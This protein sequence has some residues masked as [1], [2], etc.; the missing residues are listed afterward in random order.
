M[1]SLLYTSFFIFTV[2]L[3]PSPAYAL[4]TILLFIIF[5]FHEKL[6]LN[7]KCLIF[8][9]ISI[10][11]IFLT[12]LESLKHP[13]FILTISSLIYLPIIKTD[14]ILNVIKE[15]LPNSYKWRIQM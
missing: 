15:N 7:Y 2:K 9:T 10:P 1:K 12:S 11:L 3:F 6:S 5:T 14:Y 4:P 13:A 8:T